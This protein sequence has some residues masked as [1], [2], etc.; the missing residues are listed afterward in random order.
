MLERVSPTDSI[1]TIDPWQA[2]GAWLA[3]GRPVAI[4][5]VIEAWGSAPVPPGGV[6]TIAGEETFQGSVSGGCVEADVIA[7]A[8]DC[9]STGKPQLLTF[10]IEDKTAWRA[11]LACGGTLKVFVCRL[12]GQAGQTLI[13]SMAEHA[14][15]R[16]PSALTV[17]LTDGSFN[18]ASY[19]GGA[20]ADVLSILDAGKT[21]IIQTGQGS[22]FVHSL[23]P[24][25][26][27]AI[28][29]A[30]HIAQHLALLAKTIG[31]D[32]VVIDPRPAFTSKER[33]AGHTLV[34]AWPE[35]ALPQATE[36]PYTA[37]VAL[38]HAENIDDE[39]LAI[40]LKSPAK[41]IGALGSRKTHE[42][43]LARLREKG[44]SEKDVA[45]I[46]APIG[47]PIGARTTGEIAA[48]ILAEV[49]QTYRKS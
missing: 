11:G 31:Y 24:V 43:R 38:T 33:F 21:Q 3:A 44:F 7:A 10:G 27:L 1:V 47:L 18:L 13:A 49:I 36:D 23:L 30:T 14:Q 22:V 32:L 6:M 37:V 25:I 41:Y 29:G 20:S 9:L 4:G 28:V 48:S 12:D 17:D 45:R 16:K 26:R 34:T 42:K 2:A 39:A 15:H 8:I 19:D 46:R 40:A 5:I 35:A